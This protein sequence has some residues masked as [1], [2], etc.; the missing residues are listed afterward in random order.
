MDGETKPFKFDNIEIF[1]TDG[2]DNRI[3]QFENP[4]SSFKKGV[5]QDELQLSDSPVMGVWKINVK[6]NN[7][8]GAV[9]TFDVEEYVLPKFEVTIDV[10][11]NISFKDEIIRAKV[12]AKYTFGKIAKGN[13]TV[14]AEVENSHHHYRFG[15]SESTKKVSKTVAVDGN[16]FVEF[17]FRKE[18]EIR[19]Q[20]YVQTVKLTASFTDELSGKEATA[21]AHVKIHK[22]SLKMELKQSANRF[23]PGLSFNITALISSHDKSIPI[24]DKIN[25]VKFVVTYYWDILR[26]V[27][28]VHEESISGRRMYPGDDYESWEENCSDKEYKIFPENGVAKLEIDVEKGTK[29]FS[30]SVRWTNI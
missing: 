7:T 28:T 4:S 17:D 2:A 30:V 15:S 10:P 27:K 6:V 11:S 20:S 5:Y 14:T 25:P 21:T 26:K 29:Q 9:K 22:E 19:N 24:T 16:N 18:L 13:A 23:K 3:K 12:N 8:D 1:I